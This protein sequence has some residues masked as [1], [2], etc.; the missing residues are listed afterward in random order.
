MPRHPDSKHV[1]GICS[2]RACLLSPPRRAYRTAAAWL[3]R[4][5]SLARPDAVQAALS[6]RLY[7]LAPGQ[8]RVAHY[9]AKPDDF[10]VAATRRRLR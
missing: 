7:G 4:H 8:P 5:F 3:R 6:W 9:F 1:G 2:V 10:C